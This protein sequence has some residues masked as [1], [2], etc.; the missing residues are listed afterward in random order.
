MGG[1]SEQKQTQQSTTNPWEAAQPALKGI[2]GQLTGNLGNTGVTGAESGALTSLVN[3][4]NTASSSYAPQIGAYAKDLLNG[5]GATDQAGAVNANYQRYQDQTNPLASNTNYNPYDT[6]GFKDALST[7]IADI[8]NST[9]GQFA[10]AGRDFSGMN[11]QTLGRGILQ[12]VAPTIAAQYNQN[13]NN[14]QGAARNLYDAG[15]NNSGILA[16]LQQQKLANQG[17]GVA[18]AGAATDAANAG[19]NATLQAEAAR[20]GIPV[21][22]LGLLAQIGIPIAG[23]GGQSSGQ[24]TGTNTMSG[25]QQFATIAGGLGSLFGGG[26]GSTAGNIFKMISDQR[27]KEDITQVGTLFD[28]T[29]VYRYRYI[30]QPAFQIGLMAQDVEKTTPEAVGMIGQFKAVDYKLATDK[31]VEVA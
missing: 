16:G 21:Q 5:G 9:N 3:N 22:A 24:S 17:Q 13:V 4:A 8:T 14:Q 25:A 11:S 26:G 6:P 2:L 1:T 29:P 28:G 15:T 7:T 10:A 27:A 19:A 12:G 31:A 23:L 30:G 18:A 20:R